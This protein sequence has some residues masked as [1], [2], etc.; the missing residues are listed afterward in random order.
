ML[1]MSS[2]K[3]KRF[4]ESYEREAGIS[5]SRQNRL[6]EYKG[7]VQRSTR[8]GRVSGDKFADCKEQYIQMGTG[9]GSPKT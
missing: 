8:Y 1:E 7:I 4:L 2:G 3:E 5:Y 9:R 6:P